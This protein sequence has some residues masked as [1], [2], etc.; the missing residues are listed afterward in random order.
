MP[1]SPN[2]NAEAFNGE[3]R[4]WGTGWRAALRSSMAGLN[5]RHTGAMQRTLAIRYRMQFNQV[6]S[7]GASFPRYAVFVEKGASKG[8]GG[9]KGSRWRTGGQSRKTNPKSMGKMGTGKRPAKKWFN[10][11]TAKHVEKLADIALK[12]YGNA[13]I[14]SIGIR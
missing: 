4:Q 5:I 11:V 13:A 14:N 12:H 3:V 6:N 9:Q 10:P 7:V 2:F 1:T 8:F